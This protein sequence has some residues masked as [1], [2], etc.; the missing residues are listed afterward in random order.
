MLGCTVL[1]STRTV[2]DSRLRAAC[3]TSATI[4]VVHLFA[5]MH[6]KSILAYARASAALMFQQVLQ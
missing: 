3:N 6:Q 2:L 4:C 1:G 5:V